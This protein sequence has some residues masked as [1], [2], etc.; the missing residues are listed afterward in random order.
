CLTAYSTRANGLPHDLINRLFFFASRR[1]HARSKRDW[2]SDVCSSDLVKF[3][4]LNYR[5]NRQQLVST[6]S[7]NQHG[8][9]LGVNNVYLV[10]TT[11]R[12]VFGVHALTGRSCTF[13]ASNE[14][15]N[16]VVTNVVS[17]FPGRIL[18]KASP[19][20]HNFLLTEVVVADALATGY[21][22]DN[23]EA[24]TAKESFEL[25]SLLKDVVVVAT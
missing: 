11:Y 7:L 1:R 17:A 16:Q 5:F 3:L 8:F 22:A 2:S 4:F 19:R 24:L 23:V 20:A 9:E 13:G 10:E 18:R 21:V 25:S 6:W 12:L 14:A 15:V